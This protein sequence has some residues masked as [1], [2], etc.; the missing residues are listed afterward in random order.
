M[1]EFFKRFDLQEETDLVFRDSTVEQMDEFPIAYVVEN[2]HFNAV[3]INIRQNL[4]FYYVGDAGVRARKMYEIL[5]LDELSI[6]HL[7]A[8]GWLLCA[9]EAEL[10]SRLIVRNYAVFG[11][12]ACNRFGKRSVHAA[13]VNL[14]MVPPFNVENP[15]NNVNINWEAA[16]EPGANL[17]NMIHAVIHQGAMIPPRPAPRVFFDAPLEGFVA[18]EIDPF[19]PMED[20]EED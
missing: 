11:E 1:V 9:S 15:V 10:S 17:G 3:I 7:R 16:R 18:Q 14:G 13:F 20:E 8:Y 12:D 5:S 2:P 6:Q 19:I 4:S